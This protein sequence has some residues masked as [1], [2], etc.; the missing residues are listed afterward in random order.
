MK[1]LSFLVGMLGAMALIALSSA[2]GLRAQTLYEQEIS[3]EIG[4]WQSIGGTYLG[5]GDDNEYYLSLPFEF[6]W[7]EQVMTYCYVSTNGFVSLNWLNTYLTSQP[8][9]YYSGYNTICPFGRDMYTY[10][11]VY[12]AVEGSVGS[13]ILTIQWSDVS[14]YSPRQGSFYFQVKL[15]EGSGTAQ[16]IYGP[17]C[18]SNISG[19]CYSHFSG[20]QVSSYGP[21]I[22]IQPGDPSTFYKGTNSTAWLNTTYQPYLVP[23]KTYTVGAASPKLEGAIPGGTDENA[24]MVI[25]E[26]GNVYSGKDHPGV[27]VMRK[28][29]WSNCQFEYQIA[30]PL[31]PSNPD[32]Q[33]IYTATQEG[34]LDNTLVYDRDRQPVGDPGS[35]NFTHARG[36]AAYG[37]PSNGVENDGRLDLTSTS[38][39][40]GQYQVLVKMY[41]D[42]DEEF[43]E[44]VTR[45]FIIALQND[46]EI[47]RIISPKQN[48]QK[49]YPLSGGQVPVQ[50]LMKSVGVRPVTAFSANAK[51]YDPQ[52]NL[53][54]DEDYDWED[55]D[56]PLQTGD[57]LQVNFTNYRT[58]SVGDYMVEMTVTLESAIDDEM[59]NNYAPREGDTYYF[60]VAHEIEAEAL[61]IIRPI[62]GDEVFVGRP[63]RPIGKFKNNGVSD[64]SDVPASCTIT[65]PLPDDDVVYT[66]NIIIQDIPQGVRNNT[67]TEPFGADFVAPEAGEY[68]ICIEI[69]SP[70]D[71]VDDNNTFCTTFTVEESMDG[72]FTIGFANEGDSRNFNTIG[73]AINALYQK[74]IAG[75]IIFEFT[76]AEYN[77]GNIRETVPA[78]DLSSKIIGVDEENTITFRPTAT[79]AMT[80]GG[81]TINM[82]SGIGVGVLFGQNDDPSNSYASVNTVS[83]GQIKNYVNSAGYITFDGGSNKALKFVINSEIDFRA[84]FY[85]AEGSSNIAVKNLII[86]NNLENGGIACDLPLTWFNQG[87]SKFEYED[88]LRDDGA[89]YSSAVVMRARPPYDKF[90][91]NNMRYDSLACTNNEIKGNEIY[92]FGFGVVSMGIGALYRAG[93]GEYV[94]YYNQNNEICDNYIYDVDKAGIFLGYTDNAKVK[95]N[96]IN[97]VTGGCAGSAYGILAGGQAGDN[98]NGYNNIN[99]DINGNEISNLIA[100]DEVIGILAEQDQNSYAVGDGF[101]DFPNVA[102]NT[103]I[104]NNVIW[105]LDIEES[106]ARESALC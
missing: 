54:Y 29:G 45:D 20:H 88:D 30:G 15:Y 103:I 91:G 96:R 24:D 11:G 19:S 55:Q 9:Y 56:N 64:I 76:D 92:D 48:S 106:Y 16:I 36:I 95:G 33:V 47:T 100:D 85:L 99:L 44:E 78:I 101:T 34:D 46:I 87:L 84:A 104:S 70:D 10:G 12:W 60:N 22:N 51:I 86:E 79:R 80:K 26:R 93:H 37:Y 73:D 75:S 62:E 68:Q 67:A 2:T 40:G 105:G 8:G 21:Y 17:G 89:T 83:E 59:S 7:D 63:I 18:T 41:L 61:S 43:Y 4:T 3:E 23:G 98:K 49:K 82:N 39:T 50:M 97:N 42:D 52:G 74:G 71:P 28:D 31:P 102:E 14:Y 5:T 81:V 6:I 72:I 94:K 35:Y 65:G 1:Q 57:A 77:V 58:R 32:Y 25:L 66:D 38:I 13:R 53:V 27:W 69:D 90:G